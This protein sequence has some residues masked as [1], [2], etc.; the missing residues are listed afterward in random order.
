MAGVTQATT[1]WEGS[2]P[3]PG[4]AYQSDGAAGYIPRI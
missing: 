4:A 2:T 3:Y 1:G